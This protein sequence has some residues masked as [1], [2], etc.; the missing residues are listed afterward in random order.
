MQDPE[1]SRED[2]PLQRKGE[3][4]RE[5][6]PLCEGQEGKPSET[7]TITSY[8]R[9]LTKKSV[10]SRFNFSG[11]KVK[12]GKHSIGVFDDVLQIELFFVQR[13]SITILLV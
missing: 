4:T 9:R 1:C 5:S 7:S 13:Y 2:C 3:E 10:F 12:L 8:L 6:A 11:R